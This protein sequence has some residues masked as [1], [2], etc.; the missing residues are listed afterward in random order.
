METQPEKAQTGLNPK[1]P[2]L[3][4]TIIT[5]RVDGH[6]GLVVIHTTQDEIH[7]LL[8]LLTALAVNTGTCGKHNT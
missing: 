2:P 3:V 4:D 6:A 5:Y 8:P 1:Y 7:R